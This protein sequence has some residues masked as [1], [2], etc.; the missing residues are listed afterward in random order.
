MNLEE[1]V[2][3]LTHTR[4]AITTFKGSS[5]RQDILKKVQSYVAFLDSLEIEGKR[6]GLLVPEIE[7]Y[8]PLI[9]AI[10]KL[11][12]TVM[13]LNPQFRKEDLKSILTLLDPHIIFTV[14]HYNGFNFKEAIEESLKATGKATLLYTSETC[15]EWEKQIYEGPSSPL[16]G[17]VNNFICCSSGST[18]TPKGLVFNLSIFDYSYHLISRFTRLKA[19]DTVLFYTSTSTVFGIKSMT[20]IIKTGAHA[21]IPTS[22]DLPAIIK[23]M[24][25]TKC[26]KVITTPSVLKAIYTFAKHLAPEVLKNL[27]WIALTGEKMPQGFPNQFP[28]LTHCSFISQ[29]GVSETGAIAESDLRQGEAHIVYD[30]NDFKVVDGELLVKTGALFTE[31]F[32]NP[33]QTKAAFDDEGWYYTGDLVEVMAP[34]TLK[35]VGR[36]KDMIKKGG[37]QVNPSEIEK[38]IASLEGVKNVVIVGAPHAIYGEHVVAFVVAKG[39]KSADIRS[40]CKG[41]ISAYK[42]PDQIVFLDEL[43]IRQGKV[44]KLKLK[45]LI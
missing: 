15:S 38:V 30:E 7:A 22:F 6:V 11:G 13:P 40:Y 41:K 3:D 31:Y 14:S 2:I 25:E 18:G 26:N 23:M 17:Q 33:A 39:L 32:H 20:N 10:N 4:P 45:T 24:Q 34:R 9:L 19:E 44:D 12:G 21:V 36:K 42:I 16:E 28:L 35:I 8:L 1:K 43:P 29:Y 27:E 37:Q 5:T